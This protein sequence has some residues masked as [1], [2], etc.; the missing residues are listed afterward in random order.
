M[1]EQ[2]S[3]NRIVWIDVAKGIGIFCVIAGHLL[4]Y[5]SYSFDIII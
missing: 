2:I 4:D 1:E 3:T 5:M